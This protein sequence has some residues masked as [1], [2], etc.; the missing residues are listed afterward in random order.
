MSRGSGVCG[1]RA[2]CARRASDKRNSGIPPL[3]TAVPLAPSARPIGPGA[4]R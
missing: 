3:V 1:W 4:T 2:R